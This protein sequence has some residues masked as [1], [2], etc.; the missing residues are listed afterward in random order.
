MQFWFCFHL[1]YFFSFTL[2]SDKKE[3]KLNFMQA[4]IRVQLV[5]SVIRNKD[6]FR[7]ALLNLTSAKSNVL[8]IL[9]S[10]TV[11]L[12][13]VEFGK[14]CLYLWYTDCSIFLYL[15]PLSYYLNSKR[16]TIQFWIPNKKYILIKSNSFIAYNSRHK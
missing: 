2:L 7:I 16:S 8:R 15:C 12:A 10:S 9:F 3:E 13:F 1:Q 14:G 6:L 5:F 4:R 11:G